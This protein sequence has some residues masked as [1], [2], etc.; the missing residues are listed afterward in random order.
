MS[1]D[2]MMSKSVLI[3]S[4]AALASFESNTPIS[5]PVIEFCLFFSATLKKETDHKGR[6]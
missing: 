6:R 4:N 1:I 5:L 3:I 2:V